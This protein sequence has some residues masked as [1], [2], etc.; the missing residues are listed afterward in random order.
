MYMYMGVPGGVRLL[1]VN[2]LAAD[3]MLG[4]HTAAPRAVAVMSAVAAV[5]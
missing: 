3:F 1:F 2:Q 4:R 5:V